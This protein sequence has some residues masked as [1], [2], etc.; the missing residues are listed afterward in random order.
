MTDAVLHFEDLQRVSG[1]SR[2]ADVEKWATNQGIRYKYSRRGI[3]TT[4]EAFNAALGLRAAND[5]EHYDPA[6]VM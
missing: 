2:L 3:W 4:L 1:Y 5:A 6:S